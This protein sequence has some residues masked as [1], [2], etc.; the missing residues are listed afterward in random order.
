MRLKQLE[1][2]VRHQAALIMVLLLANGGN[3]EIE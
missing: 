1:R 3:D 2:T